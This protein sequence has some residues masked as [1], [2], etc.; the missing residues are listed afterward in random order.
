MD[1]FMIFVN[2]MNDCLKIKLLK[3]I[4]TGWREL[5]INFFV[6]TKQKNFL[7]IPKRNDHRLI[8]LIESS[9]QLTHLLNTSINSLLSFSLNNSKSVDLSSFQLKLISLDFSQLT[10]FSFHPRS[11]ISII[12]IPNNDE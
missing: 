4:Y 11:N 8:I 2:Y 3:N 10:K 5:I 9:H 12:I 6:I 7:Y 1:D